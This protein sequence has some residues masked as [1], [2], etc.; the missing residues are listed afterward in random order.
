M[1]TRLTLVLTSV[2][3]IIV[4]FL[5]VMPLAIPVQANQGQL[6][7]FGARNDSIELAKPLP[8]EAHEN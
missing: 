7:G 2:L 5:A 8:M 4:L 1:N 3:C 6:V